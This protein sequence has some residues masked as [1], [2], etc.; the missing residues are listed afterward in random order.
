MLL[1]KEE[2]E[3]LLRWA[4]RHSYTNDGFVSYTADF[5]DKMCIDLGFH[6]ILDG[7][8][9]RVPCKRSMLGNF[10]FGPYD[11]KAI[12]FDEDGPWWDDIRSELPELIEKDERDDLARALRRKVELNNMAEKY[13]RE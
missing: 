4:R 2:K 8:H 13:T 10:F 7:I 5:N 3:S 9:V 1:N 12:S 11:W 6:T